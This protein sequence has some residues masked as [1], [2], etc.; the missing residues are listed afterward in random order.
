MP[1]HAQTS[2]LIH[3][4]ITVGTEMIR[5]CC[6]DSVYFGACSKS[7]MSSCQPRKLE[8]QL[9]LDAMGWHTREEP[10]GFTQN[11]W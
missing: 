7:M 5:I 3:A 11:G 2:C 6:N 4:D 10:G 1:D 8:S 9:S